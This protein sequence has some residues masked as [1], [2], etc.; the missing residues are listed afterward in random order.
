MSSRSK[1]VEWQRAWA[2]ASG[3]DPDHKGYLKE[4]D[5]NLIQPM[6]AVTKSAFDQ[7][8]GSE[9]LDGPTRPAKMKALHSSSALAVN[10][11]DTWVT[12]DRSPLQRALKVDTPIQSLSFE[13][14]FP[15][16][17]MGNPPNLDVTLELEGGF[18]I[19]IE[20]KFSEWLTPKP[21]SK[22]AFKSKYFSTE[23]GLWAGQG[24]V[25]SEELANSIYRGDTRF[26][27]L[28]A[29]QLLKHALGLVTQL[30]RQFSLWYV[31]LQWPGQE[32][33]V[34]SAEVDLFT[35]FVG[36]ELGFK[37]LKYQE[38]ATALRNDSQVERVY[39]DYLENRY[40][41]IPAC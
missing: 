25:A 34:H 36:D 13:K 20:S 30:G 14:Q 11:F 39:I 18:T 10:F 24:L 9:L 32:A 7:G 27:Y 8:S 12:R 37:A 26:R 6:S 40:S 17:L 29:P 16:G 21:T 22:E 33:E 5:S 41:R 4:I 2:L 1:L 38:I 35:Q 3:L 31:Y 28:D 19:A 23:N 15:T